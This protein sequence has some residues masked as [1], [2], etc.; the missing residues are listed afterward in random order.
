MH[1]WQF[2]R[3]TLLIIGLFAV[4]DLCNAQEKPSFAGIRSGVSIPFGEYQ[5]TT[6]DGGSFTQPGVNLTVEGAWFFKPRI[7]IGASVALNLHPVNVSALGRAK[8][9]DDPF[10][11]DVFIRSDPYLII[12]SMMGP[13][14][15]FPIGN[16][17]SVT[18][19]LLAGL[20]YGKTPHQL[21]QPDFYGVSVP[22]YEIT[23][24]QDWKFSWQ[25]G[26]G[27]RYEVSPCVGLVIDSDLFYDELAFGFYDAS[28]LRTDHKK[29]AFVNIT[30][31]IRLNL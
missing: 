30:A 1:I 20:L 3:Y 23:S 5:R 16:K 28:G 27:L 6:L 10:L 26:A 29:I 14:A 18:G 4:T 21:Y 11:L 12:T 17:L 24:S 8:V 25:A 2:S 9:N 19:K 22:Y 7:G 31:G 13:Y 15:Q